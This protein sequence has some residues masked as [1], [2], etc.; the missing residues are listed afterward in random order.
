VISIEADVFEIVV[1]PA[2]SNAFLGVDHAWWIPDRFL[3]GEKNRDELIHAGVGEKQIGRVG[4]K[5]RRRH[6]RVLLF[7]KE[8][9]KALTDFGAGHNA[10]IK[11]DI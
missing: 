4:Q 5:R 10:G 1:F 6:N 8:I 3:L 9:E 2:G 11:R 7:A